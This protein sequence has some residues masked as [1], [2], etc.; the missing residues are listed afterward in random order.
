M[1]AAVR[2]LFDTTVLVDLL[3]RRPKAI[4]QLRLLASQGAALAVSTVTLAEI[5]AGSRPD[6]EES[7]ARL[8]AL[9]DVVPFSPELARKTGELIAAR[10]RV[11]RAYTLDDMAIAATAITSGCALYTANKRDFEVPGILFYAPQ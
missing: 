2:V 10:R 4:A 9:F 1:S 7:T 11:G 5:H 6:E 8:L 3:H